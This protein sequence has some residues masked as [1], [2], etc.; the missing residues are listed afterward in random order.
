MHATPSANLASEAR[1]ELRTSFDPVA[2]RWHVNV[3]RVRPAGPGGPPV[4]DLLGAFE[5][6][7]V[8][9]PMGRAQ[10][11]LRAGRGAARG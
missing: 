4:V 1:I 6:P 9:E 5:G 10:Q 3:E 2:A 7:N 11:L 8:S